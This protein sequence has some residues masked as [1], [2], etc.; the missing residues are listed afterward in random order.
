MLHIVL[1][2]PEIPPNTG[3]VI[4]LCANSG[5]TL[6]LI[7]PLGFSPDHAKLK[8]AG[9]DYH[10]WAK[11]IQHENFEAFL[12]SVQPKRIWLCETIGKQCYTD[13][14]YQAGDAIV[15]GSETKGL[16]Q[17]FCEQFETNQMIKI[18]MLPT[19]RSL[20]LSNCVAIVLYEAWRQLKFVIP[21]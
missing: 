13:V 15:F 16:P 10:D 5:A 18:P 1:Y 3:N 12:E 9:L 6:H 4:R 14:S 21:D 19:Q 17:A 11:V 2:Q 8:R 7:K 20:N